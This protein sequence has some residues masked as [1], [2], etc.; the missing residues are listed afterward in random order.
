MNAISGRKVYSIVPGP[1]C[2]VL[3]ND[4]PAVASGGMYTCL[5]VPLTP[6]H[7]PI[8]EVESVPHGGQAAKDVD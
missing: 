6:S 1:H 4:Q 5:S 3:H 2:P 8:C 7:D